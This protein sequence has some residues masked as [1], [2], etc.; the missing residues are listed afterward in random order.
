MEMALYGY[1]RAFADADPQRA[2]YALRHGVRDARDNRH[3]FWVAI[4]AQDAA[5]LEALYGDRDEALALYDDTIESF[6][7]AGNYENVAATLAYLAVCFE[8]FGKPEVAA[9]LYGASS[10]H[11]SLVWVIHIDDVIDRLRFALGS[12]RFD[13]SVSTGLSFTSTEAVQ[14]AHEQIA[15]SRSLQRDTRTAASKVTEGCV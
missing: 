14:Y 13:K 9:T 7:V 6:H 15:L 11:G 3:A 12:D 10:G 8:R 1:G 5:L 2:L 4:L